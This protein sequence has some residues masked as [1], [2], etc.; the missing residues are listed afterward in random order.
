MVSGSRTPLGGRAD[1]FSGVLS[2]QKVRWT[3]KESSAMS[4]RPALSLAYML[5]S[6]RHDPVHLVLLPTAFR[7]ESSWDPLAMDCEE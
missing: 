1:A 7:S 5:P 6:G 4:F 2:A 3:E